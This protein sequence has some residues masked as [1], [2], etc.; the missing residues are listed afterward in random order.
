VTSSDRPARTGETGRLL[1]LPGESG[2]GQVDPGLFPEVHGFSVRLVDHG[3]HG[4]LVRFFDG[5]DRDLAGF[6]WGSWMDATMRG[7]TDGDVPC[8]T[9]DH[10]FVDLEERWRL[11]I[12]ES[13]GFVFVAQGD[14]VITNDY[15]VW[16]TVAKEEYFTAWHAAIRTARETGGAYLDLAEA[17]RAKGPVTRLILDGDVWDGSAAPEPDF[18]ERIAAF[19]GLIQLSLRRR[20]LGDLPD[21]LGELVEL[22]YLTVA[23]N[24][25][26]MLPE[27]IGRL[28][29]LE[30]LDASFNQL[31]SLPESL[32]ELP[33]LKNLFLG[34][35]A[36]AT[37]PAA[38]PGMPSLDAL[39]LRSNPLP[40]AERE[41]IRGRFTGRR[42]DL[43]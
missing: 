36:L 22:R 16:F 42:L 37:V 14:D 8:G 11:M 28:T 6:A 31:G 4:R 10:P 27:S 38:L 24:A 39:L 17:E 35:N 18:F 15:S 25:L 12:W 1:R 29:Q 9:P 34:M 5:A 41:R 13:A 26:T 7:W 20:G 19:P 23:R 3:F 2:L 43:P 32:I 21:V 40:E 33:K 30:L